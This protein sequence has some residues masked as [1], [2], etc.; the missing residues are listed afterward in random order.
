MSIENPCPETNGR[1]SS[2]R[3]PIIHSSVIGGAEKFLM[4]QERHCLDRQIQASIHPCNLTPNIET[5]TYPHCPYMRV[6]KLPVNMSNYAATAFS[7]KGLLSPLL[8]PP[9]HHPQFHFTH[10][11]ST[12][13]FTPTSHSFLL[14]SQTSLRSQPSKMKFTAITTILSFA[15]LAL[16]APSVEVA[17]RG[18]GGATNAFASSC[19]QANGVAYCCNTVEPGSEFGNLVPLNANVLTGCKYCH[20]L[21]I[22]CFLSDQY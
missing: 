21:V 14:L 5:F 3:L 4:H 15:A 9:S 17:A 11:L 18:G 7:I 20:N 22:T 12:F 6:G 10:Q 19:Q 1:R 8:L 16:A 2:R 13:H